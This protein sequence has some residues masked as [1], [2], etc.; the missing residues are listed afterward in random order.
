MNTG[1]NYK[2]TPEEYWN[3][4]LEGKNLYDEEEQEWYMTEISKL[5]IMQI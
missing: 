5:F 1:I 2:L 4:L 3:M